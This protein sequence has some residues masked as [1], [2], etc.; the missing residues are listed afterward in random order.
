MIS[1][2]ASYF[3]KKYGR[4]SGA[5]VIPLV[6]DSSIR[7]KKHEAEFEKNIKKIN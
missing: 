7:L 1:V 4:I 5:I 3:G 2:A 6:E